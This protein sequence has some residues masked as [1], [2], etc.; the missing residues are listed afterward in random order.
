VLGDGRGPFC[1]VWHDTFG[2]ETGFRV[3]IDYSPSGERFS[4]TVPA[5]SIEFHFPEEARPYYGRPMEGCLPRQAFTVSV[6]AL[7]PFGDDPVG[8]MTRI[9]ECAQH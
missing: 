5:N 3:E 1:V 6:L 9:S 7:R 4:Y 8:G 2:D